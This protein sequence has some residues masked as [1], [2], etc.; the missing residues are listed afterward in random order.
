MSTCSRFLNL[1]SRYR[2]SDQY[3][4]T[5]TI[6]ANRLHVNVMIDSTELLKVGY[7]LKRSRI[8]TQEDVIDF[9]KLTHDLNPI[10]L[11]P[12]SA[13]DAG[14][15]ARPLVHGLLV[16]AL[17]PRII[18]SHFPGAVYVS[19]ILQ[20]K[21]P[22]YVEEEIVA[23]VEPTNLRENKN[24]YILFDFLPFDGLLLWSLDIPGM[25]HLLFQLAWNAEPPTLQAHST[26]RREVYA[27]MY[28]HSSPATLH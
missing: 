4:M 22:V 6:Q 25:S 27:V 26:V 13:Q 28:W 10:H 24:K 7:V 19:Q 12:E 17:F 14:F 3:F 21:L 5:M 16:A 15:Q 1:D 20:F 18:A 9:S 23:E 11:S 8:F 2:A